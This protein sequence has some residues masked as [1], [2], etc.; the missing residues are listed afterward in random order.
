MFQLLPAGRFL[1]RASGAGVR[2][3]PLRGGFLAAHPCFAA[4][5]LR[6]LDSAGEGARVTQKAVTS[7]GYPDVSK[8]CST[9]RTAY[10]RQRF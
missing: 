1:C 5:S 8:T 4:I 10:R 3:V 2:Y 7:R 9:I 6:T